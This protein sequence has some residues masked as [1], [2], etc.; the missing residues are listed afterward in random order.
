MQVIRL[1]LLAAF[2]A[3]ALGAS[4]VGAQNVVFTN[5]TNASAQPSGPYSI[6]L[7]AGQPVS[8][9][10]NGDIRAQCVL[11]DGT[12]R[13]VGIPTG[14]GG[15]P[16]PPG[17]PSVT[18]S[19]DAAD[20]DNTK[21]GIQIAI[22]TGFN[23]GVNPVQAQTCLRSASPSVSSWDGAVLPAFAGAG[24]L[25]LG[26]AGVYSFDVKCYNDNG[27]GSAAQIQI[28]AVQGTTPPPPP[29][30]TGCTPLNDG[31]YPPSTPNQSGPPTAF[32][33][34]GGG[35]F[36][37]LWSPNP[38]G[39]AFA[40][41]ITLAGGQYEVYSFT[42]AMLDAPGTTMFA[43]NV[44]TA[45]TGGTRG[46]D[47]RFI[48]ITECPGDLR[49]GNPSASNP[50]EQPGC[51]KQ[52]NEGPSFLLNYGPTMDPL[53]SCNL[54]ETKTYYMNVVLDDPSDGFQASASCS[55]FGGMGDCG[56]RIQLNPQ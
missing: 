40:R 48:T 12:S 15:N 20:T 18:S 3:G 21:A 26:A 33:E 1:N 44:D 54:D 30:P 52:V 25:T 34:A 8:V 56:F 27:A 51:R 22:G 39:A 23:I 28:E 32:I 17:A 50:R 14:G 5:S 41:P 6:Q 55:A 46:A 49:R 11:V 2:I 35:T 38:V 19:T 7:Q 37:A 31:Y 16:P 4:V 42:R 43:I 13:C 45:N 9:A 36:T 53:Y 47:V 24:G 29:P 10:P